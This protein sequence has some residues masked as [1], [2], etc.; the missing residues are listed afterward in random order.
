MVIMEKRDNFFVADGHC[1]TVYLFL[2][3][4]YDFASHNRTGHVDLPRLRQG[5]VG[6]QCFA[7]CLESSFKPWGAL[8]RTLVLMEHFHRVMAENSENVGLVTGLNSLCNALEKQKIAIL[9]TLE[10]GECLEGEVEVLHSLYRLGARGLGLTWNGRN[11][12]ADGVDIGDAAG[13]LTRF[14]REVVSEM[15]RLGMM[16]DASHLSRRSFYDLLRHSQAPVVVTHANIFS[17]CPH[18]RN[19]DD[20][21]LRALRDQGGVIGLS[22]YPPFIN[23]SGKADLQNLLDHYCY[24]AERFGVEM[25]AIG[26]DFDGIDRSVVELADVSCLPVLG[27]GLLGRGFS[28]AEVGR[29][30]GG[31]FLRVL[32][33]ILKAESE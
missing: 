18:R 5:G 14:G 4:G 17:I 15:N 20:D 13:G 1:D 24:A 26:S 3:D 33:N 9:L 7:V 22:F 2:R 29:I 16:V 23:E 21:Q 25:L 30:M 6:L 10:G 32:E 8:R 27:A 19:L 12:L 11:D 31:N 28:Q